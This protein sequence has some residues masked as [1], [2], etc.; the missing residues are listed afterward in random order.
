MLTF[1]EIRKILLAEWDPMHVDDLGCPLDEYDCYIPG[2]ADLLSS[3]PT[4][5]QVQYLLTSIESKEMG[6]VPNSLKIQR[7]AQI[8]VTS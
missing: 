8:L 4:Q 3:R 1:H 6:L 2:I 7:T 5:S